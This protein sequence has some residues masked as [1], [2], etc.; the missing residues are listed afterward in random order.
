MNDDTYPDIPQ[1]P[2]SYDPL[3]LVIPP[4]IAFLLMLSIFYTIEYLVLTDSTDKMSKD[5]TELGKLKPGAIAE[6]QRIRDQEREVGTALEGMAR[7]LLL[8][9][10]DN[11]DARKIVLDMQIRETPNAGA[12]AAPGAT[13]AAPRPPAP[14]GTNSAPKP[15]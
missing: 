15:R 3:A 7:D 4:V 6:L 2:A 14:A 11:A 9:S 13:N 12:P 5:L 1:P 10:Q 8:M